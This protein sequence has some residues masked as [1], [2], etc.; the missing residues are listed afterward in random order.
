MRRAGDNEVRGET[1]AEYRKLVRAD[2][3]VVTCVVTLA[4]LVGSLHAG[5]CRQWGMIFS[6]SPNVR[7]ASGRVT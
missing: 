1:T 3:C 6:I 2:F 7:I 4:S 5:T